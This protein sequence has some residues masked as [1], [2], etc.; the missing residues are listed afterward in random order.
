MLRFFY[1]VFDL[2]SRLFRLGVATA[3]FWFISPVGIS[4]PAFMGQLLLALIWFPLMIAILFR[5][6][7]LV[8]AKRAKKTRFNADKNDSAM[9]RHRADNDCTAFNASM[10][11]PGDIS[12]M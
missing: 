6:G 12:L 11:S 3:P 10:K 7:E 4:T 9:A 2:A 5:Q 1:A 8:R